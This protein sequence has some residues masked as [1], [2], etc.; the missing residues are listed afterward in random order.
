MS[1]Q[2]PRLIGSIGLVATLLV[3]GVV[4]VR[5]TA[6]ADDCP[7]TP[8]SPAPQGSHWHYRVDRTNQRKCWYLRAPGHAAQQ[9]AAQATSEAAPAAQSHSMRVPSEP[10]P[11]TPA[12]S[13]PMSINP[14]DSAPPL[15]HVRMLAVKPKPV[16][17]D[18]L[19]QRSAQDGSTERSIPGAPVPQ[20]TASSQTSAQAAGSAPAA[21]VAWPDAPP[22]VAALKAQESS[23]FPAIARAESVRPKAGAP[24]SDDTESTTPGGEPTVHAGMAGS[25]TSTPAIMFPIFALGLVAAGTLSRVLMRIPAARRARVIVDNPESDWVDDQRQHEWRNDQEHG[26]IDEREEGDS[27]IAAASDYPRRADDERPDNA[28]GEGGAALQMNEVSKRE[29]TLAQLSQDLHRLL[30]SRAA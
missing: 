11:A 15:P 1:G 18:E 28:R 16:S 29:D 30:R 13:A 9:T 25:L 24:A 22:T 20:A 2:I 6:R 4:G 26:F 17:I 19:V 12:A 10:M 21:T 14:S 27:L 7:T 3:P 5:N 23:G 8:K